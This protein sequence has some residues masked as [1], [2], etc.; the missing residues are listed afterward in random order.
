[1]ELDAFIDKLKVAPHQVTFEETLA[2]IGSRYVF[3][4]TP[5]R[6]GDILNEADQNNGSCKIFAFG[7]KVGLSK[8]Q[9]L[10]CFGQFYRDDVLLNPQGSDHVNI[11]C[12]MVHGWS[13]I[14]FEFSPLKERP[15]P[16]S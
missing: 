2:F 5:F 8:Q 1:M 7:K 12:F 4:S 16:R 13:G 3:T 14:E 15:W 9:T 11:R 6:N 10:A